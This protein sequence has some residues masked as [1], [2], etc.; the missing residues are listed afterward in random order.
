MKNQAVNKFIFPKKGLQ[1]IDR[2]DGYF[3]LVF[4]RNEIIAL[5]Y[6]G[7]LNESPL[8]GLMRT[9]LSTKCQ[10]TK[11]TPMGHISDFKFYGVRDWLFDKKADRD[12]L[13][14]KLLNNYQYNKSLIIPTNINYDFMEA[15]SK[16]DKT[17]MGVPI[18][19]RK[20][21][22]GQFIQGS[23]QNIDQDLD[24]LIDATFTDSF[25]KFKNMR[26]QF[27]PEEDHIFL[28]IGNNPA[29]CGLFHSFC[30]NGANC[31]NTIGKAYFNENCL[32][33][34]QFIA[35]EENDKEHCF[36]RLP[37]Y[38][39]RDFYFARRIQ[40]NINDTNSSV[41]EIVAQI[42]LN[43]H[44][45]PVK[46]R[47]IELTGDIYKYLPVIVGKNLESALPIKDDDIV[48]IV[49][50]ENGPISITTFKNPTY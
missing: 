47:R 4:S 33:G 36:I 35:I 13:A 34:E 38:N 29:D 19:S 5:E 7:A 27:I 6:Y 21:L 46:H 31:L 44:T 40:Y 37:Y 41:D 14:N 23:I 3:E 12:L 25:I 1:I 18:I 50:D 43:I 22:H 42:L 32:L 15:L 45:R 26:E 11:K 8:A 17:F 16:E 39:I 24:Q 28:K 48:R 30:D 20:Y 10:K 2:G 49:Q 9:F